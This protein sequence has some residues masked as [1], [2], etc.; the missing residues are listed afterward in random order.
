MSLGI[1]NLSGI[2]GCCC[3]DVACEWVVRSFMATPGCI[4][5]VVS[6]QSCLPAPFWHQ[7]LHYI[8]PLGANMRPRA[9]SL[10]RWGDMELELGKAFAA[11][12]LVAGKGELPHWVGEV[13]CSDLCNGNCA[14]STGAAAVKFPAVTLRRVSSLHVID[15]FEKWQIYWCPESLQPLRMFIVYLIIPWVAKTD[16]VAADNRERNE[17]NDECSNTSPHWIKAASVHCGT[18][19]FYPKGSNTYFLYIV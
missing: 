4:W 14:A 11:A 15:D 10:L 19:F 7:L 12:A 6:P 16:V 13:T 1:S 9:T 18:A 3:E 2:W 17:P 8:L 5:A